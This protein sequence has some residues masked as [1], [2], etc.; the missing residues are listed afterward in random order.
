MNAAKSARIRIGF[1]SG[2][3]KNIKKRLTNSLICDIV[4]N[5]KEKL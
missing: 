5:N 4:M 1:P 3:I 2:K